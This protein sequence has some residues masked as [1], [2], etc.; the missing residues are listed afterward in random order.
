MASTK[1]LELDYT[2]AHEYV[3]KM[4]RR[5]FFWDG[6]DMV[7][8]VPNDNGFTSKNGMFRNNR[9]GIVFRTKVS[10][11]GIWRVKDV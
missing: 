1:Y 11:D 7:R 4:S 10:D 2:S 6:W 8:W 5:G 9:W 3:D